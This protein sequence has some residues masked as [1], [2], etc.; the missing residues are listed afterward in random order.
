MSA[1]VPSLERARREIA[2]E[3]ARIHEDSHGRPASNVLVAIED[4]FV[5][6]VLEVALTPAERALAEA[7]RSDVVRIT[8][9]EYAEAIRPVYEASV[10]RSTGRR[11]EGFASRLALE[12]DRPWSAEVF[13]LAPIV[14]VA[15]VELLAEE[16]D[17]DRNVGL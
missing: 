8:R 14:P 13:L 4:G 17:L 15:G 11:V 7:G 12:G 5:A 3:V 6:V 2:R 1:D 10:E 16:E 9:E